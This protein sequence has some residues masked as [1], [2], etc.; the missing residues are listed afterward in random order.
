[1]L[2]VLLAIAEMAPAPTPSQDAAR[3]L[4]GLAVAA[5]GGA[6]ALQRH[7]VFAW[8]GD[9]SVHPAAGQIIRIAGEWRVEP[10]DRAVVETFAVQQ[11]PGS[12]RTMGIDNGRGWWRIGADERP[13]DADTLANERDQFHLYYL[14]RLTPL[15][16]PDYTL[17]TLPADADGRPGLRV[18][19]GRTTG[20]RSLL[21]S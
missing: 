18:E 15:L 12:S 21:R 8:H 3:E 14:L 7:G 11:G 13:M 19:A 5:A 20:H 17:T 2:A 10:P 1:M 4:L 16:G 6:E 9:A